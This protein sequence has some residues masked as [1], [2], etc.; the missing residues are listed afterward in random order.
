MMKLIEYEILVNFIATV[1][2]ILSLA[3]LFDEVWF[4]KLITMTVCCMICGKWL[5]IA[6]KVHLAKELPEEIFELEKA[7]KCKGV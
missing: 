6:E 1:L 5:T 2:G 4:P 3:N 7:I